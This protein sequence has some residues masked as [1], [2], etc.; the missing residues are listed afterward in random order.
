MTDLEIKQKFL[1]KINIP[2]INIKDE[3]KQVNDIETINLAKNIYEIHR[4]NLKN[5]LHLKQINNEYIDSWYEKEYILDNMLNYLNLEQDELFIN[6]KLSYLDEIINLFGFTDVLDFGT[7]IKANDDFFKNLM[8]SKF[9]NFKTYKEVM[10]V[11][12]K[13]IQFKNEIKTEK[14]GIELKHLIRMFNI[15][16]NEFGIKIESNRRQNN[17]KKWIYK[18]K[19]KESM[20]KIKEIIQNIRNEPNTTTPV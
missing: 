15:I 10:V 18:Y 4:Y 9:T 11:F 1:E 7:E 2:K 17:K 8:S 5:K 13:N 6:K 20:Y 3:I 16:L 19:F 14:N 12:E